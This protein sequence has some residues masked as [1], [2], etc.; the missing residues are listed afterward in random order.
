M[1]DLADELEVGAMAINE[2]QIRI[3]HKMN[4]NVL[5]QMFNGREAEI[6]S[7]MGGMHT[8]K[9]SLKNNKVVQ[10]CCCMEA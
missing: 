8:R 3:G 4:R 10:A 1:K 7:V 6:R 9:G 5:S 2:H